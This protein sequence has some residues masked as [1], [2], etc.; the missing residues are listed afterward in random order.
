MLKKKRLRGTSS[1]SSFCLIKLKCVCTFSDTMLDQAG[2]L[3][4]SDMPFVVLWY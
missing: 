2:P 3:V 4:S 1:V